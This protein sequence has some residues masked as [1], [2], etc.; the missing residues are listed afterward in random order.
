MTLFGSLMRWLPAHSRST[1]RSGDGATVRSS[2]GRCV[3]TRGAQR[4]SDSWRRFPQSKRAADDRP[5]AVSSRSWHRTLAPGVA[6]ERGLVVIDGDTADA[7]R[8]RQQLLRAL[9]S[10]RPQAKRL[11]TALFGPPR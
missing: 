4:S 5:D 6:L 1:S 11:P 10:E 7:E 2:F 8:I 9:D 3:G